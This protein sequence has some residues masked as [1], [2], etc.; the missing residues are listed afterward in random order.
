VSGLSPSQRRLLW[1]LLGV[2]V[3]IRLIPAFTHYGVLYDIQSYILMDEA[4]R[5]DGL[6]AYDAMR[7]PY[8]PGYFPW[9][10]LSGVA[11]RELGISFT[12]LIKVPGVF[13]DAAIA[14]LVCAGLGIR[15][16]SPR[17]RLA[18]AAIV[19]FGPIFWLTSAWHGQLDSVAIVPAVLALVIWISGGED[20]ALPAG[21]LLGLAGALKTVPLFMLLAL[22]PSARSGRERATL[23]GASLGLAAIAL[24]PFL[25]ANFDGTVDALRA[26]RG[27]PGWGGPSLALQPE[28]VDAWVLREDVSVSGLIERLQDLQTVIVGAAVA[29][30][31]VILWRRRVD[32]V[33]GAAVIWLT[34]FAV[35]PNFS[36]TYLVWG[37]P[38]FLI[39]GYLR[40]VAALQ[41]VLAIPAAILYRI[42][43][44]DPG[45]FAVDVYRPL[46]LGAW[47]AIAAC[48][49]LAIAGILRRAG[50]PTGAPAA[51]R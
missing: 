41:L 12:G 49:A 37:M 36:Y 1:A 25:L 29:L 38:C 44:T 43:V 2:G 11:N 21:L 34:V 8:G 24:A 48:C 6:R 26:N 9:V 5:D 15:G 10:L 33:T 4:L 28:L 20:R 27:I 31:G 3:V 35:N 22:L 23:T 17:A 30:V 16:S 32:P 19:V 13:A 14:Y 50:P 18:G 45:T 47:L 51:G 7:W 42:V 46:A 40:S 39:A